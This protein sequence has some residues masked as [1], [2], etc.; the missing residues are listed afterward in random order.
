MEPRLNVQNTK[1]IL[2]IQ[3]TKTLFGFCTHVKRQMR[4]VERL[5]VGIGYYTYHSDFVT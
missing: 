4:C 3:N 5:Q 2:Y 1:L